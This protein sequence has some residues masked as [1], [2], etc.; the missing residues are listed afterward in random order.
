MLEAALTHRSYRFE[1]PNVDQDNQRLEFLGDA[2]LGLIAATHIYSA[3]KDRDEGALTD[4]RSRVTSGKAL[5]QIGKTMQLGQAVRLGK[6]EEQSGGRHRAA[7]IADALEAVLGAAY[8]DGGIKGVNGIFEKL[9]VP[10]LEADEREAWMENP[11]GRL[12]EIVQQRRGGEP[13][14]RCVREEGPPHQKTFTVEVVLNGTPLGQGTGKSR[15]E[16]ESSAAVQ[17]VKALLQHSA[18]ES[19]DP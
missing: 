5:A 6:G 8:L 18:A 19:K 2:V 3:Y 4:L 16:A 1:T 9:F 17:A 15:R 11:K 12:Q 7:L 14:Y 13:A 10:L